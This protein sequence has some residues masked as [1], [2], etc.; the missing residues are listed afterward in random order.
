MKLNKIGLP[1][2]I[3]EKV[4]EII[5]QQLPSIQVDSIGDKLMFEYS[6]IIVG[7]LTSEELTTLRACLRAA[8]YDEED[9]KMFMKQRGRPPKQGEATH[10]PVGVDRNE[11]IVELKTFKLEADP[12][13]NKAEEMVKTLGDPIV[14]DAKIERTGDGIKVTGNVAQT[15]QAKKFFE[16]IYI[17]VP[18]F[19]I[20]EVKEIPDPD[21]FQCMDGIKLI[22]QQIKDI[23]GQLQVLEDEKKYLKDRVVELLDEV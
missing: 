15:E 14:T 3:E 18:H 17:A 8:E 9:V 23:Q 4:V 2:H 7:K 12:L 16:D 6:R 22:N 20:T 19:G 11:P 10:H 1:T 13:Q 5:K 21:I